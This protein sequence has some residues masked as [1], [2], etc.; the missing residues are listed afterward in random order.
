MK[1]KE[2]HKNYQPRE[3]L[4]LKGAKFLSNVELLAIILRT[5]GTKGDVIT[6]SRNL[7]AKGLTDLSKQ[8][9]T[10][11][12]TYSGIGLAKACQIKS[13]FELSKRIKTRRGTQKISCAKDVFNFCKYMKDLEK[14]QFVVLLLDTK[15]KVLSEDVV[16]VGTLNSSIV[17]PRE[18]F[19]KA[20]R[21]NCNSIVLV[22]NHPSGDSKPSPEDLRVT[23]KLVEAGDLLGI[24]ILDHVIIGE[25]YNSII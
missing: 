24:K 9:L 20:I 14:E 16:S 4:K 23:E 6:L 5:G 18:V 22:H 12:L 21:E 1:L 10:R 11:L 2:V 25:D 15:N 17:H 7:L 13:V 3:K 19:K 8:G